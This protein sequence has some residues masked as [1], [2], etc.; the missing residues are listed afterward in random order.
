[1]TAAVSLE[2][3]IYPC[4]WDVQDSD[5]EAA[6]L[7]AAQ[8][9][10]AGSGFTSIKHS[11][12]KRAV[13]A[14]RRLAIADRAMS[15]GRQAEAEKVE[16][17][18]ALR[19]VAC[20]EVLCLPNWRRMWTA[21]SNIPFALIYELCRL[22]ARLYLGLVMLACSAQSGW[23]YDVLA[24]IKILFED[25][26]DTLET[27]KDH[28]DAQRAILWIVCVSAA[29]SIGS[30]HASFFEMKLRRLLHEHHHTTWLPV[31]RILRRFIWSDNACEDAAANLWAVA[32]PNG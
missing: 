2:V 3:P 26:N 32:C 14:F 31:R 21:D 11:L 4:Y 5:L 12:P 27:F 15:S 6:T 17:L 7:H 10:D 29:A 16:H 8:K 9:D 25:E 28:I 1:M 24:R 23:H 18:K 30:V 19:N 20:H 22:V 13:R